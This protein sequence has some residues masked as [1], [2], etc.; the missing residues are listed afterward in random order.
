MALTDTATMLETLRITRAP[1]S[2]FLA[3]FFNRQINFQTD[4]IEFDLV[5]GDD[6]YLAP[7][8]VPNVQGRGHKLSGYEHRSFKPAYIKQKDHVDP[9][10]V[11]ERQPGEALGTGSLSLEQ[12][13]DIVVTELLRQQRLRINNRWEWMAAKA[14]IDGKVTIKGEDYPETLVDFRRHS[15]L[16]YILA[17]AA[18]WSD[19]SADPLANLKAARINAN[20]R[21]GARITKHLFGGEAW[22]KFT[23]RVNLKDLLDTRYKDSQSEIKTMTDGYEGIEYIG[24]V[25]SLMDGGRIEIW[26][27]TGKYKDEDGVEQFML[28]QNTVVGFSETAVQGVRCYGAI[29]DH[30]AGFRAV[31][32]FPKVWEENDPPVEYMMSQSAPLMVPK[33]PDATF[34][35]KV[36]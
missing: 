24:T 13:H 4:T 6:R 18:K 31:D 28:D 8:V 9:N 34:S 22:D 7:F 32:I 23:A 3:T 14:I 33:M 16:T 2:F 21:S 15:S 10:M 29:K 26:V 27:H 19:A 20:N 11:I 30:K 17:G 25:R 35:I 12:R 36:D 5:Y 1:T